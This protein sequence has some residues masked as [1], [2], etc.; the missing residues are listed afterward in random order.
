MII[1]PDV[2]TKCRSGI[3]YNCV[4]SI[5]YLFKFSQI[6]LFHGG[7][8]T[9]R[10]EFDSVESNC[11]SNCVWIWL[12]FRWIW[13]N[14]SVSPFLTNDVCELRH[15]P[16][17]QPA[18]RICWACTYIDRSANGIDAMSSLLIKIY[19][20]QRWLMLRDWILLRSLR[21]DGSKFFPLTKRTMNHRRISASTSLTLQKEIR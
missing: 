14:A 11:F 20:L 12:D 13:M 3:K 7:G 5:L 18:R 4:E 19:D 6:K 2:C 21:A 8:K 9:S 10:L 16:V 15:Q 17:S 1:S